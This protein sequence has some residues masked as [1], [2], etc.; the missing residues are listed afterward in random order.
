MWMISGWLPIGR[1]SSQKND[2]VVHIL[3]RSVVL[4]NEN[5]D[6]APWRRQEMK[7]ALFTAAAIAALAI[8][9][10]GQAIDPFNRN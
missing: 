8:P 7:R 5:Q 9:R 3:P 6:F 4:Y 10:A 1:V 2:S